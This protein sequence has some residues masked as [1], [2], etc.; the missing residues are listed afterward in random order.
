MCKKLKDLATSLRDVCLT[1]R[2]VAYV[3]EV[4]RPIQRWLRRMCTS[5]ARRVLAFTRFARGLPKASPLL[6][7]EGLLNHARNISEHHVTDPT[8]Q[9]SIE[10]YVVD[11]FGDKLRKRTWKH[12]PGSKNAVRECPG[13]KGGYD[14]HLRDL[15]TRDLHGDL[16]RSDMEGRILEAARRSPLFPGKDSLLNRLLNIVRR[17]PFNELEYPEVLQGYGTLLSMENFSKL[18]QTGLATDVDFPVHVATPIS[19]QGCKVRV[20]TV[21]PASIF[22]AGTLCRYAVFPVLR[23]LDR[24]VRDF[25]RRRLDDDK[26]RGFTGT[27]RGDQQYLSADLTKATDG[28]SH[29]AIRAVLRGLY[30]AGL[31]PAYVDCASRSL[32]VEVGNKHY[33]EYPK[34]SFTERDWQAVLNIPK[35]LR[36]GEKQDRVRVPMERGCLMGTPLS[37]TILS[38]LNGWACNALGP[39]TAICGDDVLSVTRPRNIGVYRQRV[40]AIG[41]G[42]H[43]KKS[44][45]GRKGWTFCEVFGLGDPAKWYN[46]YPVKQFLRDGSGVMDKGNY[47][48]PQW[49]A[50]R[51]V[52][53]VLCK[54]VRAKARRLRRPPELPVALGGLGHPSKGVR[55]MPKSVR[56]QLYTLLFEGADPSKYANRIDIFYSPSDPRKFESVR[57]MFRAGYAEDVAFSDMEPPEGT[58][59]VTNRV[60]RAHIS[61]CTHELYWALGGG[62]RTCLPKAMKPGKLKLPPVGPRQF[63]ARTPWTSVLE[64][65]R[66]KLD[67]E[68][69]FLP[70]DSAHEI[71]G[72]TP[73]HA[74]RPVRPSGAM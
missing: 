56:S 14:E 1:D 73:P 66:A 49:K 16:Y 47:F 62:Y 42:L 58:F 72:V 15:I 19:E 46:P 50:L 20:I 33:V 7:S 32:G 63:G 4:P 54:P 48:A 6:I 3:E 27:L 39:H 37:F 59:F 25:A 22:T 18:G 55:D 10:D 52:A 28:F 12:A 74:G 31:S 36:V 8:F 24:R 43:D 53:R 30:R 5:E 64:W 2:V 69:K 70:I 13:S 44:F 35:A 34:S 51:R 17:G 68:G 21:P 60:F 38:I 40:E 57:S 45:F 29:D 65:W 26:V 61:R 9:D 41:S 23:K 67:R 11:M 71:R